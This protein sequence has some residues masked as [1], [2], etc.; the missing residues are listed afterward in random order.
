M[1]YRKPLQS[2]E[3]SSLRTSLANSRRAWLSSMFIRFPL[4][5]HK[6]ST[7]TVQSDPHTPTLIG[8]CDLEIGPHVFHTV[9]IF[10]IRHKGSNF[11]TS[12]GS[13]SITPIRE[14]R[15]GTY[16]PPDKP[17]YYQ[18]HKYS[19]DNASVAQ[20][21]ASSSSIHPNPPAPPVVS[22]SQELIDQV[23]AESETDPKL[24]RLLEIAAAGKATKWELDQ[25]ARRIHEISSKKIDRQAKS[26][27][28]QETSLKLEDSSDI[29]FQF[30]ELPNIK[31]VLPL[32]GAIVEQKP[33]TGTGTPATNDSETLDICISYMMSIGG[34]GINQEHMKIYNEYQPITLK[35]AGVST[36]VC[37]IIS[38]KMQ[39]SSHD[40]S[41][42]T[43]LAMKEM[44]RHVPLRTYL[45]SSSNGEA[46]YKVTGNQADSAEQVSTAS[47]QD[48]RHRPYPNTEAR[49]T[50]KSTL[51]AAGPQGSQRGPRVEV[52]IPRRQSLPS[53]LA[54]Q[55]RR[56][57]T[58]DSRTNALQVVSSTT[59]QRPSDSASPSPQYTKEEVAHLRDRSTGINLPITGLGSYQQT[60]GFWYTQHTQAGTG[61]WVYPYSATVPGYP[62]SYYNAAR[63]WFPPTSTALYSSSSLGAVRQP[64]DS[65]N[66]LSKSP[67]VSTKQ[68]TEPSQSTE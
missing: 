7:N 36:Q 17:Y 27:D 61:S 4:S 14:G 21:S 59:S 13:F 18:Q 15:T 29:L 3:S 30:G 19:S 63:P 10:Q 51:S 33:W 25:L 50:Q 52:V 41:K 2:D 65:P 31:W 26:K 6:N 56:T 44:L 55:P 24:K 43:I 53:H 49:K 12:V 23:T 58:V 8:E 40:R 62:Y 1:S 34:K 9:Q 66:D 48:R 64:T 38:R 39:N 37:A 68:Q 28:H 16:H 20:P 54:N 35:L 32:D 5:D 47:I 42:M 60:T 45:Q 57:M 67:S 46:R 22:T 11:T